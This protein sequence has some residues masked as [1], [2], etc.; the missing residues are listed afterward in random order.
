MAT[1]PKENLELVRGGL[2][3]WIAAWDEAWSKFEMAV[4][5]AEP[6]GERHVVAVVRLARKREAAARKAP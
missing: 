3:S 2:E 5:S 4:E 1:R 6:V